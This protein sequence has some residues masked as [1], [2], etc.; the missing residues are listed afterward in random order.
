MRAADPVADAVAQAIAEHEPAH[1]EATVLQAVERLLRTPRFDAALV[2][3]ICDGHPQIEA[4]FRSFLEATSALPHPHSDR[5]ID[6]GNRMFE[7]NAVFGFVGLGCRSLLECYC[8]TIEAEVLGMTHGMGKNV[9]RR[10]PE[11]A[12]F[13]LDV[14]SD[15]ALLEPGHTDVGVPPAPG[16]DRTPKGVRAVQKIRL[17]H[18]LMRWLIKHDPQGAGSV[19]EGPLGASPFVA[20][21][22][23]KWPVAERG[24]PI[25]Q[26]FLAGTLLTFSLT[27]LEGMRRMWVP[28]SGEEARAY[29][30]RWK[31]IGFKLGVDMD[32]L[33]YFDSEP[34]ARRLHEAMMLEFR[35]STPQGRLMARSLEQFMIRNIVD[36]V[37]LHWLFQLQRMP[38]VAMWH[39]CGKETCRAV[40]MEPG[41]FGKT[42]GWLGW[43]GLRLIGAMKRL[44]LARR[45]S[46][47]TFEWLCRVMWG[48][49]RD[50]EPVPAS[51]PA[52]PVADGSTA[53]R[54]Q[55]RR[56]VVIDAEVAERLGVPRRSS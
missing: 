45:F 36:R 43:Q 21:L 5:E 39:L 38:C 51:V 50:D 14:M 41:L 42:L 23:A 6:E 24:E 16:Q 19:F 17:L 35:G 30:Q 22:H 10:I 25:S 47:F 2:A 46:K 4:A 56:G 1:C 34:A 13:V 32:L 53:A 55:P 52:A 28:V 15:R 29:L 48:W 7:D 20:M 54:A 8:W 27:I 12:M 44:P 40:G 9:D 18:A 26:A 11:T 31:V 33:A 37:P 3:A 49:R